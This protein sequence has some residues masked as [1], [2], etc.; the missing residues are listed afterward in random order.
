MPHRAVILML[1]L[2]A[3]FATLAPARA[4]DSPSVAVNQIDAANYPQVTAV[5]TVLDASG[6]PVSN[7]TQPQFAAI[8]GDE[9]GAVTSVQSAQDATLRLSVTLVIDVS[10]SMAGAPLAAAKEA[11][12]AFVQSLGPNDEAALFSF[13]GA[14]T[15]VVPF[16]SD[17][18]AL[19]QGIAGLQALG[20]TALYDAVQSAVYAANSSAAPRK[21]IVLLSDGENDA[22]GSPSTDA[23]SLTA[24]RDAK[25]PVFAI[26]FGAAPGPYLRLLA[27]ETQGQFR[28]ADA[29]DISTVYQS[30][31][32]LLRSQ[33][34]VTFDAPGAADGADA[35]LRIEADV[36]GTIVSSPPAPFKRGIAPAAPTPAPT[37][38]PAAP[39]IDG[40]SGA[41]PLALVF[42][43]TVAAIALVAGVIFFVRRSACP[44]CSAS[45]TD[46]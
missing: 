42:A 4:Q 15:P 41:A 11:A 43:A 9:A 23:G 26:G 33:Y 27:D 31:A 36:A 10:G 12:S 32:Q 39:A 13:A 19:A 7:L 8:V 45:T 29:S 34:V 40:D 1:A 18:A 38:A 28:T 3:A 35:V 37:T 5:V 20:P 24:A 17:K 14:V 16:T 44:L 2:I 25:V 46:W 21:A 22:A 6:V 30:I